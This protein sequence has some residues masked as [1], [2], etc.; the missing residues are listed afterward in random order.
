MQSSCGHL[1]H[2]EGENIQEEKG[3]RLTYTA[4]SGL[5]AL[6]TSRIK[7]LVREMHDSTSEINNDGLGLCNLVQ[8]SP[9]LTRHGIVVTTGLMR[10]ST[11]VNPC[12]TIAA[13]S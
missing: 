1:Y 10:L 6:I 3:G 5:G 2:I 13:S 12:S 11:L 9:P 8:D 7:I 4:P